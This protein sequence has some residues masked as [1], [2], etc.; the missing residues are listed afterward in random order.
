M[1]TNQQTKEYKPSFMKA[2]VGD[3][4]W[5]LTQGHGKI[6]SITSEPFPYTIEVKFGHTCYG[7]YTLY[8]CRSAHD[9]NPTLF[10]EEIEFKIPSPPKEEVC[11]YELADMNVE[12]CCGTNV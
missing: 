5:S 2:V 3:S 1:S 12:D 6:I 11:D 9:I 4:V 7:Q 10:W 8:G